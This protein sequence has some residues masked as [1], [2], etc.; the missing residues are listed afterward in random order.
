MKSATKFFVGES[1]SIGDF[2]TM[3]SQHAQIF[4][5][6]PRVTGFDRVHIP[7][8]AAEHH[9]V[10]IFLQSFMHIW[11]F[12]RVH[13]TEDDHAIWKPRRQRFA[14]RLKL[15]HIYRWI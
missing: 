11:M 5:I 14:Q 15:V 9:F 12:V 8:L 10:T 13:S 1:F 7:D 6:L 2:I 3:P 4:F